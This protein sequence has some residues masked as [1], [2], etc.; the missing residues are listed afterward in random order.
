MKVFEIN[1]GVFGSTGRIMFGIADEARKKGY[2]VRCASPITSTNKY[3]Q[4]KEEYYRI[5]SDFSRKMSV[6]LAKITGFNGCFAFFSTLALLKELDHFD[7]DIVH[8]HTLHNSYVNLPLLFG[9]LKKKKIKVVWTLHDCWAFT[10]QCPHFVVEKCDKWKT[11]CHHCV[12]YKEYPS[13]LFDNTKLM[14][15]L[16][17]KWFTG[18]P[19]LTIVTPSYWL[20]GLVKQ[21]YLKDQKISV[22]QNGIDLNVFK[23]TK[24]NRFSEFEGKY[25]V[26]GVAFGWGFRKGLDVFNMLA[27]LLPDEYQIVLVGTDKEIEKEIHKN[28]VCIRRT[29]NQTELAEIYS[30]AEV[31]VNPTRED[32]FPTV[33]IEAL[34]CGL[35]V[36][37][38]DTGGS[39]EILDGSCGIVVPC[40]NSDALIQAIQNVCDTQKVMRNNAYCRAKCFDVRNKFSEYVKLYESVSGA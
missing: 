7:P 26:L 35:P 19:N 36:I 27:E 6:L 11:S 33:N 28:I 2:E 4:P 30:A 16:K 40:D 31:F 20:E 22:I 15:K 37:T 23:P 8:L 10:G 38:F 24:S 3:H 18:L 12:K 1:G 29:A 9:Y 17:K 25:I 5:G 34:A 39:P 13:A 21:S 14:W 32:T